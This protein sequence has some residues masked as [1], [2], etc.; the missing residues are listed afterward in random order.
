MD[1]WFANLFCYNDPVLIFNIMSSIIINKW[2]YTWVN[3]KYEFY[4]YKIK[5]SA[6]PIMS[7]MKYD[8]VHQFW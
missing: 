4:T 5:F 2:F 1:N 6:L 3:E 7:I 8:F